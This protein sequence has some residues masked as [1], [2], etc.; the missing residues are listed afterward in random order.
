MTHTSE[1]PRARP[2]WVRCNRC[3]TITYHKRFERALGVCG[4]GWHAPLTAPERLAQLLDPGSHQPLPT[5]H[6]AEDP[7]GF[8]D[9]VPYSQRLSRTR[10]RTGLDQAVLCAR[11]TI[12][13]WPVVAAVMDF[14]FLGGSLGC[15]EGEAIT[16]AAEHAL[17]ERVPLLMVTASGGARM[18][19]GTL[20]L[21]QMAKTSQALGDL[22]RAG[23]PAVSLITDPTYGGVAAS[24][25]TLADV[26]VAEPGARMGFAGPRVIEQTIRQPLPEGF[27]T[28]E[29]LLRQGLIDEVRP[30]AGLRSLL[31]RLLGVRRVPAG[32]WDPPHVPEVPPIPD[33]PAADTATVD[34]IAGM[35][36]PE[37]LDAWESVRLARHPDRPTT[38]DHIAGM[39]DGFQELHGDRISG[40]CP[41]IVGGIAELSGQS[42]VVIGHQKG[43][44]SRELAARNFGMA[45]PNGYRKAARLM[46]LAQK[47]RI[48]VITLIDTPGA[49]PGR[50][51]EEQ[52][53]AQAIAENIR[54]MAGLTVPTVAVVTGEGGSGGALALA[55]AD[56][57][58]ACAHAVYSV[59]SPEGCA[60]IVWKDPAAAPAA[61][62][63]LSLDAA[64]LLRLGVIDA[65]VPEPPGGAHHDPVLATGLVRAAVIEALG[66]LLDRP[67]AELVRARAARFRA[68]GRPA[69]HA[70]GS[71]GSAASAGTD[72][73]A[74]TADPVPD[75]PT[76]ERATAE[77]VS[78]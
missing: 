42:V 78:R 30:R 32:S 74:D 20:S 16:Q 61:A 60:A 38:L 71:V 7:L 68:F 55:V 14:R 34:S 69:G 40:D 13:G 65:V 4:C 23:L 3:H 41:A 52:G 1:S 24:F 50:E 18:Q 9:T 66:E 51:A 19:E 10:A 76:P 35:G 58:L 37:R 28:A 43:H 25:A 63:A 56:R 22:D 44:H 77:T 57:V 73:R 29:L 75:R 6:A 39:F 62:T 17:R 5:A 31:A 27:Q 67:V 48:P 46:R 45:S 2:A 70:S 59:I 49:Y 36:G 12:G 47:L 54:L 53:Q 64:S 26:V 21:M 8:V 33:P 11:G 15:S 72:E